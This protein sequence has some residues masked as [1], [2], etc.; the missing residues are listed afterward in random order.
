MIPLALP[1]SGNKI[2]LAR[3]HIASLPKYALHQNQPAETSTP[4]GAGDISAS[5]VPD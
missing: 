4:V 5:E 1:S 2:P 3:S